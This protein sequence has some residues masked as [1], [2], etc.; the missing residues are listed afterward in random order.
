MR[1]FEADFLALLKA[2]H[3]TVLEQLAKGIINDEI[4]GVLEKVGK[5]L[6]KKYAG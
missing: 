5:D 2:S 1:E 3:A 6:S 4:T